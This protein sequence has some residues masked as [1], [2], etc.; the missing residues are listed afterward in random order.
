ML[1]VA[2]V[3]SL[4]PANVIREPEVKRQFLAAHPGYKV[5]EVFVGEGWGDAAYYYI[6]YTPPGGKKREAGWF[7]QKNASGW[8]LT[9]TDEGPLGSLRE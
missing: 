9:H 7:Y 1:G 8:K 6:F 4:F 3:A 5:H 2:L